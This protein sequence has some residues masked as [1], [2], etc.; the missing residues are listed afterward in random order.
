M[1]WWASSAD[2]SG[3]AKNA[4]KCF[5]LNLNGVSIT[6]DLIAIKSINTLGSDV[7]C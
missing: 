4:K 1:S 2:D 7:N 3:K 6:I 5:E